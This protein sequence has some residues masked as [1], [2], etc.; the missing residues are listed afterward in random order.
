M[1]TTET[2]AAAQKPTTTPMMPPMSARIIG[3]GCPPLP[4][5]RACAP[6]GF[7]EAVGSVGRNSAKNPNSALG[8]LHPNRTFELAD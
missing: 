6:R 7:N 4:R 1:T 5:P 2:K 3:T 8:A